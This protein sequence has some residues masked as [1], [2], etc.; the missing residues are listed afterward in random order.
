MDRFLTKFTTNGE[1]NIRVSSPFPLPPNDQSTG[2]KRPRESED[3]EKEII[4]MEIKD[5][6]VIEIKEEEESK[7]AKKSSGGLP[8]TNQDTVSSWTFVDES[9]KS[10]GS[11]IWGFRP[12]TNELQRNRKKK[13][14][15][16]LKGGFVRCYWCG[17]ALKALKT[18]VGKHV[19][20]TKCINARENYHSRREDAA[21]SGSKEP[22]ELE[23]YSSEMML[24]QV[25]RMN[26]RPSNESSSSSSAIP[27]NDP[28]RV[29]SLLVGYAATQSLSFRAME[30]LFS[31]GS[32]FLSNLILLN[33]G[34]GSKTT[35]ADHLQNII[36]TIHEENV[37]PKFR[38]AVENN[39]P[40]C[41][42]S[43]E[44]PA[45]GYAVLLAHVFYPGLKEPLCI[46]VK[47]MDRACNYDRLVKGLKELVIDNGFLTDEEYDKH[48]MIFSGDH[49]AYVIKAAKEAKCEHAGDP[50]HALDLVVK[51]IIK[52]CHLQ[53]LCMALRKIFT[54]KSYVVSAFLKAV[55]I[56]GGGIS[57]MKIPVTRWG[58][59]P[60]LLRMIATGTELAKLQ[61]AILWMYH[62]LYGGDE[63]VTLSSLLW[64]K[65]V[66]FKPDSYDVQAADDPE[67]TEEDGGDWGEERVVEDE[68]NDEGSSEEEEEE[69]D[70]EGETLKT[71]NARRRKTC[72]Q[73]LAVLTNPQV[74]TYIKIIAALTEPLRTAQVQAQSGGT[75]RSAEL[76]ES[77]KGAYD[78]L[79]QPLKSEQDFKKWV[80]TKSITGTVTSETLLTRRANIVRL[81]SGAF[82]VQS[83]PSAPMYTVEYKTEQAVKVANKQIQDQL[84]QPIRDGASKYEKVMY[85]CFYVAKRRLFS[86]LVSDLG[87]HTKHEFNSL[88]QLDDALPPSL[89]KETNK[90]RTI[91]ANGLNDDDD[92]AIISSAAKISS[93][94]NTFMATFRIP[95]SVCYL[96]EELRKNPD[97]FWMKVRTV[98]PE[99]GNTM[100][101][102]L[103]HPLGTAGLERDFSGMTMECRNFRKSR[104][105]W[106][107]FRAN[108]LARCYKSIITEKLIEAQQS[109]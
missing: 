48:V 29:K 70:K 62:N 2:A 3:S 39:L 51:A 38:Y 68:D 104:T 47:K 108:V 82:T 75:H 85:K 107:T 66:P 4:V 46:D 31:E 71:V 12:D 36:K 109:K 86:S 34:I 25:T 40:I 58:Y 55:D 87:E 83:M 98:H 96:N 8:T 14:L 52:A 33:D 35:C 54:S 43:D 1:V 65:G 61:E 102:W 28:T 100:L 76:I 81:E 90:T 69:G 11:C 63:S 10:I 23:W 92:F 7:L 44:S 93:Q 95:E 13:A 32:I 15:E 101:Y 53:P 94:W 103:A 56:K 41:I 30:N 74:I 60:R 72:L 59:F 64:I 67:N 18:T 91:H 49:A 24:L 50:A 97:K 77:L 26:K 88:I 19:L 37:L 42:A 73:L 27:K 16:L 5:D 79:A 84:R 105:Q 9:G 57:V 78:S 80:D 20:T 106:P 45:K 17:D 89:R 6:D 21:R 22:V 99:L